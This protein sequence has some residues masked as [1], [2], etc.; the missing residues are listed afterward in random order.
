M[1]HWVSSQW[2]GLVPKVDGF[3][4]HSFVDVFVVG[5]PGNFGCNWLQLLLELKAT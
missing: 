5:G 4:G 3:Q 1:G 2:I